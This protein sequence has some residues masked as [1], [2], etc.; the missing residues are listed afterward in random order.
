MASVYSSEPPTS[1]KVIL[2]TNY[3][4]IDIE[5]WTKEAPRACKNFIQL[6]LEGYYNN[7]IFHRIIKGFMIQTGDPTGTGH[8]GESIWGKEFQDEF[9]SR[10]RFSHRGIVAM[11]NKNSPNTNGSQFFITMDKCPWLDKKH[12]IFGKIT[13]DTIF[14]AINISQLPT[15]DDF[16][17]DDIMPKI[18]KTEVIINPFIDIAPRIGKV[19]IN[20]L[21]SDKV[22]E[23]K[24]YDKK[25]LQNKKIE[26]LTNNNLISFDEGDE[27]PQGLDG[28]YNDDNKEDN[29]LSLK[30]NYENDHENNDLNYNNSSNTDDIKKNKFFSNRLFTMKPLPGL[31]ES[32]ETNANKN[33]L[34]KN[35]DKQKEKIDIAKNKIN[36][37]I[38][39]KTSAESQTRG[40]EINLDEK[41]LEEGLDEEKLLQYLQFK[42]ENTNTSE[43]NNKKE[44]NS[45][46]NNVKKNGSSTSSSDSDSSDKENEGEDENEKLNSE[47]NSRNL[48]EERKLFSEQQ[49]SENFDFDKDRKDE[50]Q[51][52]KQEIQ[53]IKKRIKNKNEGISDEEDTVDIEK[54]TPL[55]EI[56]SKYLKNKR[57][58]NP[59]ET[60]EKLNKFVQDLK[61]LSK[62]EGNWM[63]NKLKF[64][65][66]SQKAFNF[67]ETKEKV[68]RNF[69]FGNL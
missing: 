55:Q 14:N 43:N 37:F 27:Q 28:R 35:S 60:A 21:R 59:K 42:K 2:K 48:H 7:V 69:D 64:H 31:R 8:S 6:C 58:R 50:I 15:K 17:L 63:N 66:D 49:L 53:S 29:S 11:A 13:G 25:E 67:N 32:R 33:K 61:S 62:Q 34:L 10:L 46:G 12:T 18:I 40:L 16:P 51:K 3:G 20:S 23:E 30:Y 19:Q 38:N 9:H 68:S 36:N 52:I 47:I 56:R 1:G 54:L 22:E 65:T 44:I 5:L 24:V 4:N 57:A 26:K 41:F 45:G 39:S